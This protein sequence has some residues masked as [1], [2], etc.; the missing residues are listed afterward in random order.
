V[1]GPKVMT[2]A[3][4]IAALFAI[5]LGRRCRSEVMKRIAA[6]MVAA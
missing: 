6:P 3:V 5:L 4:I 2:V 1:C